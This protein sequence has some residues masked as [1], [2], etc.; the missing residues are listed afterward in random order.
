MRDGGEIVKDQM[1]RSQ[2]S[3]D[4]G[5]VCIFCRIRDGQDE[6]ATIFR[7][8]TTVAFLDTRPVFEG[9]VLVI[10]AK[11][12]TSIFEIPS[13]E[14]SALCVKVQEVAQAVK[15]AMSADGVLVISNN[16]VSQSVAHLH[17]HVIPRRRKDG[18]RGFMW[19]RRRYESNAVAAAVAQRIAEELS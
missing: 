4:E 12:Y 6:S 3:S 14:F 9:H 15:T 7:N 5:T 19:P 1:V 13:T 2:K 11:H 8:E 18:L 16:G 17:V 10:P